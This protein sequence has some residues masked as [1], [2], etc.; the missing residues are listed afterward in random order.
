MTTLRSLAERSAR[1]AADVYG[2]ATSRQRALPTF[3]IVGAQ[4]S[5]TTTLFK[6]LT[7][8]PGVLPPTL[9]KGVHYFDIAYDHDLDW[10]RRHFP[11]RVA[12][13]RATR[14]VGAPAAVGESSPY[15]LWHPAAPARIAA[16]L[17]DVR[18]I[19][20]LRDPVERA[21]SAWSHER[22]RGYESE[23]FARA[24]A[25]EAERL[26]GQAEK[27]LDESTRNPRSFAHQHQ[28]YLSRG[29]YVDQLGRMAEA[30][31]R[32]QVLV[33]DSVDLWSRPDEHWPQ[34]L[35]FLGLP[36]AP[37][38]LEKHNARTRSPMDDDLRQR[39]T[40]HFADADARLAQWWGR[41]PSWRR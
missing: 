8:H 9:R 21:Y 13:A 11:T 17:P 41:T 33:L 7:Q 5:G 28:A 16:A 3:L 12:V 20:V 14:L 36:D 31:G 34:V 37:V 38:A 24:L 35:E 30:V 4:R 2:R 29:V 19:A 10:Y 25:L 22:A 39:L 18:V 40:E 15:Y 1:R 6:A 26:A 23:E 32:D 27:L